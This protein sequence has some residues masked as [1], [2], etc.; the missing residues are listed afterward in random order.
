MKF[1]KLN[2]WVED[3]SFISIEIEGGNKHDSIGDQVWVSNCGTQLEVHE[4]ADKDVL[5]E[6]MSAFD[7]GSRRAFKGA[8]MR[9]DIYID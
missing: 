4:D 1:K 8:L 3:S 7:A 5:E 9:M 2:G 6:I